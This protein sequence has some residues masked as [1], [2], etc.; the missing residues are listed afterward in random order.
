MNINIPNYIKQFNK[1]FIERTL[2]DIAA[3]KSGMLANNKVLDYENFFNF[4]DIKRGIPILIPYIP[5]I[6]ESNDF[7]N[8]N[9]L[10]YSRVIF[11]KNSQNYVGSNLS[12]QTNTFVKKFKIKKNFENIL[13]SYVNEILTSKYKINKLR[14]KYKYIGAFQTRNVP[15]LGHEKIIEMM[16]DHCDLVVINP[17]IGPKKIGD[18]KTQN[19]RFIFENILKPRFNNRI[20]FIPI[21]ANMYY[22]GPREAIHHTHIRE[23]LG[24]SHFSVGRDHAGADNFYHPKAAKK[25]LG[26]YQHNF[27]INVLH[28]DGAYYCMS[29]N[30][31]IL[32]GD[33]N[34]NTE[35]LSEISGSKFR[36]LLKNKRFYQFAAKDIQKWSI[37][38]YSTLF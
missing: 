17:I 28:H 25:T 24:F 13:N 7:F 10:D 38:N 1:K 21:R 4:N 31:V 36:S 27:K 35:N 26:K 37:K 14:D 30:K 29:C 2:I 16:L 32:K 22:A 11:G 12:F 23:W 8:L 5:E 20:S 6:I 18:V 9:F 15:H 19:L 33:C 34:H 3:L